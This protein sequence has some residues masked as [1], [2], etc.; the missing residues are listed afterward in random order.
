MPSAASSRIIRERRF[1]LPRTAIRAPRTLRS[2][3]LG[4][5]ALVAFLLGAC[6]TTSQYGETAPPGVSIAG[7]WKL[8][9]GHSSDE[10]Q[11]LQQLRKRGEQHTRGDSPQPY[12]A[13]GEF[14]RDAVPPLPQ[15]RPPVDLSLQAATLHGGEWLHIEMRGG[16]V[17]IDNGAETHSFTPGAKSVVSVTTGVADQSSGWKG[18]EFW[19]E[20]R[21][22]VGPRIIERFRLSD[23]GMHLIESISIDHEGRV[24]KL[25]LTRVYDPAG[26]ALKSVPAG[27]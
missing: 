20:V 4:A 26:D 5:L 1:S 17:I 19:I 11:A 14:D 7:T 9:P 2:A 15:Y 27:D 13:R 12:S 23:D 10:H 3:Q 25:D 21:P 6:A 16:E 22:Q 8:N 18:K 24:P